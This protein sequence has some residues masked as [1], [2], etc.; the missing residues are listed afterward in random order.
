[1]S[2]EVKVQQES[3]TKSWAD[4]SD[5]SG[6]EKKVSN[7]P[8]RLRNNPSRDNKCFRCGFRGHVKKD[9]KTKICTHCNNRG[10]LKETCRLLRCY[11]CQQHGHRRN[12]CPEPP[13]EVSQREKKTF[14]RPKFCPFCRTE[15]HL[16]RECEELKS[17]ECPACG[18][19]GHM[20]KHC[21]NPYIRSGGKSQMF[22]DFSKFGV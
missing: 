5:S 12:E 18:E 9:C 21:Q 19:K 10:H 11:N 4:E 8:T 3:N 13:K 20:P 7:E 1:M 22:L 2:E 14:D 17:Y 15:G 6:D 16:M